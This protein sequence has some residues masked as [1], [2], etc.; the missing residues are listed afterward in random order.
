MFTFEVLDVP[1]RLQPGGNSVDRHWAAALES[2]TLG[3]GAH[4]RRILL[5]HEPA[6]SQRL[7]SSRSDEGSLEAPWGRENPQVGIVERHGASRPEPVSSDPG[8]LRT[9]FCPLIRSG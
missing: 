2:R 1:M 9:F 6:V 4:R 8:S 3:R 7:T 5:F